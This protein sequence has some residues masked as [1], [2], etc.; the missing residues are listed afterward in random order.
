LGIIIKFQT[1]V[2]AKESHPM[3]LTVLYIYRSN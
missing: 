2:L 1:L 3:Y